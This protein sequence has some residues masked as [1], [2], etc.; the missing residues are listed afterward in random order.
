MVTL[1][2]QVGASGDDG[3]WGVYQK[4]IT[5]NGGYIRIGSDSSEGKCNLFVRFQGVTIPVGSTITSAYVSVYRYSTTG[6]PSSACKL[7]FED[8]ANPA[9]PTSSSDA[10]GR[11]K[12]TAYIYFQPPTSGTWNNS[13]DI[14]TII[15][16]LVDSYDYSVG[17]SML[18]LW[19]G[20]GS[21]DNCSWIFEYDYTG[22]VSGPKLHIEYTAP[23]SDTYS[24]RGFGR[25]IGRGIFR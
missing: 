10:N 8:S 14:S 2:Y 9:A 11:T 12:T 1:D 7:Y 25:G 6:S 20:A 4:L 23:A 13:G 18:M 3:Y 24:G 5:N 15:Q 16:E 21:S 19:I 17:K 22:N